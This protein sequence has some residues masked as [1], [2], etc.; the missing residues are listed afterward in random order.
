MV[1]VVVVYADPYGGRKTEREAEFDM[2]VKAKPGTTEFNTVGKLL[3]L[4][5]RDCIG[6]SFGL[7]TLRKEKDSYI[8]FAMDYCNDQAGIHDYPEYSTI[9]KFIISYFDEKIYTSYEATASAITIQ[10]GVSSLI[11]DS[12]KKNDGDISKIA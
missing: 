3:K 10:E 9:P 7:L 4:I 8:I 5:L 12:I 1:K 11:P 2:S 6:D